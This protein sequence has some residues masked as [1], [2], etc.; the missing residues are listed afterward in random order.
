MISEWPDSSVQNKH[1][2]YANKVSKCN[3]EK[4]PLAE[5]NC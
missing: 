3:S 2:G 1:K 5:F 4:C